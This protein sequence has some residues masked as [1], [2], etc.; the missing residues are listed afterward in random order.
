MGSEENGTVNGGD[1]IN[2]TTHGDTDTNTYRHRKKN[3]RFKRGTKFKR[4]VFGWET[5]DIQGNIFQ[6][7]AELNDCRQFVKTLEALKCYINKK[8]IYPGD[9]KSLYKTITAPQLK[10]TGN[11][12]NKDDNNKEKLLM[13][14]ENTTSYIRRGQCLEDNPRDIFAVIWCQCSYV[15]AVKNWII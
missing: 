11:I 14:Q 10:D 1:G 3:K 8:L 9:L 13:W 5:T 4:V 12:S 2:D 6:T 15:D 7:L